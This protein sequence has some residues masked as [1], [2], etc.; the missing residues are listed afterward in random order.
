MKSCL[1]ILNPFLALAC[2]A[3]A[4][5]AVAQT[6]PEYRVVKKV[7]LGAPDRD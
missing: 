6:A 2:L 5:A 1:R 4:C 7:A 3:L